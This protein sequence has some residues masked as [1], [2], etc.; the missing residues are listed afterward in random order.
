MMPNPYLPSEILDYIA[1]FLHNDPKT[2][3]ECC[4]VSKPCLKSPFRRGQVPFRRTSQIMEENVSRPFNL[5]CPAC[6]KPTRWLCP[7]RHSRRGSGWLAYKFR[8]DHA[9]GSEDSQTDPRRVCDLSCPIS[10]ILTRK[11]T[12]PLA[13]FRL[14]SLISPSRT[15][16]PSLLQDF[17]DGNSSNDPSTFVQPSSPPALT[18]S[19]NLE[20]AGGMELIV[21]QLLSIPGGIHFRGLDLRCCRA[22]DLSSIIALVEGCSN[23]LKSL[24][25]TCRLGG[26]SILCPPP[27]R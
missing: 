7:R 16:G 22:E 27:R 8:P 24:N 11:R 6:Q 19:L 5:S 21:G 26:T 2:L 23:T 17:D 15:P 20:P 3:K 9:L 1:D 10:T 4:L 13:D 18:G 14:H 12:S 25:I